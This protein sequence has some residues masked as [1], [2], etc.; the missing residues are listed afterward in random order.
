MKTNIKKTI[1][2]LILIGILS[3]IFLSGG[4]KETDVKIGVMLPLSGGVASAGEDALAA[5]E[6]ARD[7]SG[8]RAIELLVE[9]DQFTP[10]NS[11]TLFNKFLNTEGL[12]AIIGPLNGTSIES[13][14]PLAV[15]NNLSLF[16]PWG[17]GNNIGEYVYKNSVEGYEEAELMA[18]KA[19]GLGYTKLAVVYLQNDFGMRYLEAFRE[20]VVSNGAKLVSEEPMPVGANDFRSIITKVKA[21]NPDAVYVVNTS[22]ATGEFIK[23]ANE[24]RLMVPMLGQYAVESS[25]IIK[26]ASELADGLVY[27]FP[28]NTELNDAQKVF[29]E[30]FTQKTGRIPSMIAYNSYDIYMALLEAIEKCDTDRVCINKFLSDLTIVGG[31]SG[32]FTIK[33]HKLNR[34]LYFKTISGGEFIGL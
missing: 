15:A 11:V 25:D 7:D 17:A 24:I 4:K 8:S 19:K 13:L 30:K 23:Q 29:A 9:D 10:K 1:F 5:I 22:S 3:V 12:V 32:D 31:I 34:D 27:T 14:R 20:V 33:D 21:S 2:A 18:K 28:I 26:I 6:I 16:T